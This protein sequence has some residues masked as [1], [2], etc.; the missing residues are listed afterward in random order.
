MTCGAHPRVPVGYFCPMCAVLLP[1]I[2]ECMNNGGGR[3][4]VRR[5]RPVGRDEGV[6]KVKPSNPCKHG[7]TDVLKCMI[8]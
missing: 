2:V 6:L 8:D 4:G 3:C 1:I 5:V 7:K